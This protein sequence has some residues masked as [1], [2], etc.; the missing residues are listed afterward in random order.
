[1]VLRLQ[2]LGLVAAMRLDARNGGP[3][4]GWLVWHCE[5]MKEIRH[6]VFVDDVELTWGHWTDPPSII[7]G[8]MWLCVHH[9]KAIQIIPSKALVLIN[10]IEDN[11]DEGIVRAVDVPT[12][13]L[14]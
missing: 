10:P 6:C 3:Y 9:A 4:I 11:A 13:E 12:Q 8:D 1:M 7:A 5:W 2:A 14:V